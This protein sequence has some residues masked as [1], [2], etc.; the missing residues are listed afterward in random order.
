M[1]FL[2]HVDEKDNVLGSYAKKEI[3][4]N[5]MSH[6]IVHVIVFNKKN[7]MLLQLQSHNK[8]Y[9][10]LHWVS[11]TAGHVRS[12]ESYEEAA[13]REMM[14]EIG[15]KTKINFAY[16]D[17]ITDV[18][19]VKKFIVTFIGNFEG[20]FNF[21]EIEVENV[22]FFSMD[23]IKELIKKENFHPQLLFILKKHYG[24]RI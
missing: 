5:K 10:P 7:E 15:I 13:L 20:P 23:E 17:L 21:N 9:C 24:F 3:Y 12:K 8:K 16:K 18:D 6:R 14:E 11:S 19:G 22:K 4:D 1:E 2:D